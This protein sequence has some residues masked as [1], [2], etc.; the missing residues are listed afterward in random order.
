MYEIYLLWPRFCYLI[1]WSIWLLHLI[2]FPLQNLRVLFTLSSTMFATSMKPDELLG[3]APAALSAWPESDNP[4]RDRS[5]G[6]QR[7]KQW[8]LQLPSLLSFLGQIWNTLKPPGLDA[9]AKA[10]SVPGHPLFDTTQKQQQQQ[11]EGKGDDWDSY[12]YRPAFWVVQPRARPEKWPREASDH[13]FWRAPQYY[14]G[15]IIRGVDSEGYFQHEAST[16]HWSI[17]C[18]LTENRAVQRTSIALRKYARQRR[19]KKRTRP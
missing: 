3:P 7:R 19:T 15:T 9:S 18:F 17:L 13:R 8:H 12:W 6:S 16:C 4:N 5:F 2:T 10:R 14:D 1:F 11:Y